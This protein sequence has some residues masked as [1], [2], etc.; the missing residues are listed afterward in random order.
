M[1]AMPDDS[2]TGIFSH[3]GL[4][5]NVTYVPPTLDCDETCTVDRACGP[6]RRKNKYCNT[7]VAHGGAV[8]AGAW[9]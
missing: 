1:A 4:L 9:Q 7:A 8:G 6:Y 3:D 2:S 5:L